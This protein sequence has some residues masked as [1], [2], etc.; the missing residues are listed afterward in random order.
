M[1]TKL[2]WIPL[3]AGLSAMIALSPAAAATQI[4]QIKTVP[5][6]TGDQFLIHPSARIGM[7]NVSIALDDP[8]LDPFVNPALGA[9]LE[10]SRIFGAPAYYRIANRNGS[11]RT[12]PLGMMLAGQRYFGTVSVA[13]QQLQPATNWGGFCC[14]I[15]A[16]DVLINTTPR[17]PS[18]LSN[19]SATNMYASGSLGRRIGDGRTAIGISAAY[20]GLD[21]LDGVDLLYATS[22]SIRQNGQSTDFRLGLTR[23]MEEEQRLDLLLVHSRIDMTH[24][25]R[26]A[27]V[28]WSPTWQ[29]TVVI[30]DVRNQDQ[31]RIWGAQA[32][33]TRPLDE[34]GWRAGVIGRINYM[35]HPKIPDYE[36][37]NIP[38]D[39]GHS[40]A[41]NLG[42]GSSRQDG[43]VSFGIDVVYEPIWSNTW[44]DTETEISTPG[45]TIIPAGGKTVENDFRFNNAHLR[46]GAGREAGRLGFQLGLHVRS[47]SYEMDQYNFITATARQQSESWMEWTPTWGLVGR[48][49]EIEV[50]YSGRYISGTG[51]PGLA[52]TGTPDGAR[53]ASANFILA[54]SGPLNLQ[55]S[56]VLSHQVAVSMPIGARR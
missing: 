21:A 5:V 56:G 32:G 6:A 49:P 40:W 20:A 8:L 35:T 26:Y 52:F 31:T 42:L 36:I 45:G 24:D 25:V 30:R 18:A 12:L 3:M 54:P 53:L 19:R 34:D 4:I 46:L 23:A 29:P 33:Y 44:A 2:R 41:Y 22:Q 13:L 11:G 55:E 16:T 47:I 10:Q 15:R 14:F 51:R 43:P 39:P 27:D 48:F 1:K 37:M 28:T 7:A 17:D 9:S 50:R 38:R